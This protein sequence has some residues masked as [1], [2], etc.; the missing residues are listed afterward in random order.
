MDGNKSRRKSRIF[1]MQ[2]LYS[3]NYQENKNFNLI[4]FKHI[5]PEI[6]TDMFAIELINGVLNN[7]TDLDNIII[8]KS[9]WNFEKINP[10]DKILLR[11]G[12]FEFKSSLD[13][14]IILNEYIEIAKNFST[15]DSGSFINGVLDSSL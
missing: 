3:L 15:A 8:Q 9:S 6:E 5:I 7:L 12:F 4:D 1:A 11:L 14:K 2:Y 13:K 10:I